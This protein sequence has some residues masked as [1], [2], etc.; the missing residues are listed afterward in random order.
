MASNTIS[1]GIKT[2]FANTPQAANDSY[3]WAEDSLLSSGLLNGNIVTLNVMS[4]DLGGNAKTLFSID[5]GNGNTNLTD[6]DLLSAGSNG[7]WESTSSGDLIRIYNGQIELDLSHSLMALGATSV[8]ALA[9]GD[10]IHDEFVYAIRLSNGALS[11]AKVTVDIQGQNDAAAISGNAI[12]N[13]IEAGGVHNGNPGAPSVSGQLT[14]MDADHG[15][16]A[17]QAVAAA[18]LVGS[19]GNF[20]FDSSTGVWSYTLDQAKADPLTDGQHVTDQLTV[21]SVDGTASQ[22][23]AVN[24]YGSNDAPVAVA[25]RNSG[26]ED[27]IIAG[28]VATNDRDPDAGET[29]GLTYSLNA[30]VAGLTLNADGSYTLDA[31]HAAYQRLAQ[32]ITTEVLATY[33]VTDVH[34]ATSSSTLTFTLTGVND[35]PILQSAVASA[36]ILANNSLTYTDTLVFGDLDLID[37]HSV[38]F[39]PLGSG[40]VGDFLPVITADANGHGSITTTYGLTRDQ[41]IANGGVFPNHQDYL[42]TID[43]HHGG[44]SSQ[45]VSIPLAQILSGAGGGG[46]T[47]QPP[48]ATNT[49]PPNLFTSGHNLGQITDNPFVLHPSFIPPGGFST[50]LFTH[51]VLTFS[52]PDGG[53][54]YASVDLSHAFI[55]GHSIGNVPIPGAAPV[56]IF[57]GTWQVN[58]QEPGQISWSYT[59]NESAIRSMSQGESETIIVPITVFEDGVG[60][61]TQNVRIDLLGTDEPTSLLTP[62]TVLTAATDITPYLQPIDLA[63]HVQTQNFSITEDPLVT[64]SIGNHTLSGTIS[65]VDADHLD[66]PTVT[67]TLTDPGVPISPEVQALRGGFSYTVEQFGNY[68]MI[69]W[70]YQVQDSKLD[71]LPQDGTLM[72][73]ATFN[74]GATPGGPGGGGSLS[75]VNVTL[76]GSNDAPIIQGS[77]TTFADVPLNGSMTDSFI[78]TDPDW[79]PDGHTITFVP[80]NLDT[81]GFIV[82]GTPVEAGMGGS[83]QV[84]WSYTANFGPGTLVA[85]QHDVWDVVVQD[86]YGAS[87]IHTLDFHLV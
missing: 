36:P 35:A 2:S 29:A 65:F 18:A 40:Y 23:I 86:H 85:G 30:P 83:E 74:I 66:R 48:V 13:V 77:N 9:A 1:N 8:N 50:D 4:N 75:T 32:G 51:G 7:V 80:H 38:T 47:V 16:A 41:V 14:V 78:F 6:F 59:L 84:T 54:H 22:V 46:A 82:G 44:T 11:Q 64:G 79:Y 27:T 45:I 55:A 73:G 52:D 37:T 57:S 24:I 56:G 70:K 33:T 62:N 15:Q 63:T 42:V 58:V 34:G 28:S 60:Q 72:V 68:G 87:A 12:G 5:D 26:N 25:D 31:G 76:H 39:A 61:S 20:T 17:F 21:K 49:S 53:N 10:H 67:M 43:D 81:H 71:F 3:S 19:Y 69:H